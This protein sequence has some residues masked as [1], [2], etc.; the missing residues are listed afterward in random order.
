MTNKLRV[1]G[2]VWALPSIILALI[3]PFAINIIQPLYI[4]QIQKTE[5]I[6]PDLILGL[7][8]KPINLAIGD[9]TSKIIVY[10]IVM[11]VI[12]SILVFTSYKLNLRK[13]SRSVSN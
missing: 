4:S 1:I 6:N 11:L 12:G 3:A 8:D 7:V 10:G 5:G 2:F 9:I 13:E